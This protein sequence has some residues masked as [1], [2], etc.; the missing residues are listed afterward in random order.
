MVSMLTAIGLGSEK[1]IAIASKYPALSKLV[2]ATESSLLAI[3]GVGQGS[4][5][6]L[7]SVI[8]GKG[9]KKAS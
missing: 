7:N 8:K 6:K 1:S 5:R 9:I 2:K 3:P 4:V